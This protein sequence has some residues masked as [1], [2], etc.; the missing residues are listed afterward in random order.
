KKLAEHAGVKVSNLLL[1]NA[2]DEAI[3][4]IMQTYINQGDEIILPVPTFAMFKFY[5]DLVGAKITEVLYNKD[6]KFPIKP[7]LQKISKK[8]KIVVIVNPN[9]P[10]GTS[11][12]QED[13]VKI[14]EKAKNS[15]VLVDEA[16]VQFNKDSAIDLIRKYDNLVVIQTFSKA[17]GLGGLRLGYIV[18]NDAVIKIIGKVLSPYSVNTAVVRAASAALDDKDYVDWYIKEVEKARKYVFEQF[19]DMKIKIYETNA[20]FFLAKF[21]NAPEVA[22]KLK[23]KGILVRDR[24]NYPL[25]SGCLRITI[26]SKNQM[27]QLINALKEII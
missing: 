22:E 4:V 9:N 3:S 6:L 23:E 2:T 18:S 15:I 13:I 24:S 17:F 20:N 16:Y 27:K 19:K 21:K 26:G 7:V 10:T 14:L 11:I 8:T 25:L 5:A 12:K 1:T